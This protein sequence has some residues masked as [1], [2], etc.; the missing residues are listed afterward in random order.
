LTF[1]VGVAA[2]RGESG[3]S[4]VD[5]KIDALIKQ[6]GDDSFAKREAASKKLETIGQPALAALRRAARSSDDAEIQHRAK[7]I[8]RAIS[9]RAWKEQSRKWQGPW[10]AEG[11]VWMKFTGKRWSSGTPTFGPVAGTIEVREIGGKVWLADLVVDEGPTKGQ[12]CKA[13]F[14]L[15]GDTLHYCGTYNGERPTEFKT[16]VNCFSCSFKRKKK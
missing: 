13:I 3:K 6:L 1:A 15:D 7:V 14:R 12:T 4:T 2:L 9:A 8:I 10:E 5:D 11:G 16:A